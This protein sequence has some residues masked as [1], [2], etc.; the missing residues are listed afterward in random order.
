ME[1]NDI[2]ERLEELK[3]RALEADCPED[4]DECDPIDCEV[5]YMNAVLRIV[6]EEL[7]RE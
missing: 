1:P 6:N 2:V 4:A 5:C 3:V 7:G